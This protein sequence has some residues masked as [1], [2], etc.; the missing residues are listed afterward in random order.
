MNDL[1]NL[2]KNREREM[3]KYAAII[4][5]NYGQAKAEVFSGDM[6]AFVKNANPSVGGNAGTNQIFDHR[7]KD[8]FDDKF[9]QNY[10]EA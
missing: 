6:N 3:E 5:G 9:V 8:L 7:P 2:L 10:K 4:G 1:D